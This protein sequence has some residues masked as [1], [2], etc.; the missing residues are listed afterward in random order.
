MSMPPENKEKPEPVSPELY[1]HEYFT[2]DCE[3]YGLFLDGMEE[4][5]ERV[6]EALA[7]AGELR[8]KR[9]LDIGCGRGELVCEA[10][11]RGAH[12]VGIDYSQAAIEL[13]RERLDA[14]DETVRARAE[15][16]LANAKGLAFEDGSFDV[17]FLVDV[18]EHLHPYEIES[19]LAEVGRVLRPGGLLVV[20][21]GPNTWFYRFG[22][23]LVREAARRLLR[24]DFPDNLRGQY[25][26]VMH[27]NEQ[28]PLS[29]YRGLRAAGFDA[30]VKPRSFFVGIQPN[31][32]E[33][34]VMRL[35]FSRPLAY[36][37]CTSL[38]AVARPREGG[39]EARL[40][41]NR[42][43]RML[44]PPEGGRV[45]LVGEGEGMLARRLAGMPE[46]DVT[47]L[48]PLM[49]REKGTGVFPLEGEG[50]A[51]LAGDPSSL[52]FPDG[53]FDAVAAQFTLDTLE[54][55]AAALREWHRVLKNGGKLVLAARNGLFKG[56]EARPVARPRNAFTP[57]TL[58]D[59]AVQAG[60]EDPRMSTL[61]P[62]LK[63][64][65]LYRGDLDF[66]LRLERIPYFSMRG[67]VLFLSAEKPYASR[68][69]AKS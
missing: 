64:P 25:D 63:L 23:P 27:V 28:N 8:E 12:A 19:T 65:A 33:S 45:L 49:G 69:G 40:R 41:V 43:L 34:A 14:L 29:L 21:T 55:P 24:R 47:W 59:A 17:V 22:Y 32:W 54:E 1:T 42:M 18:Y 50:Y 3:G 36:L 10:A 6:G 9:V 38:M 62:D 56:M 46:V 39:R 44:N 2:T 7:A 5:S 31:R 57:T 13:S 30:K 51:R 37:F 66:A 20:H 58:K 60:F 4:L 68:E 67:K 53:S 15:F 48:E 35:L 26:D 11:R 16:V 52:P 61:I